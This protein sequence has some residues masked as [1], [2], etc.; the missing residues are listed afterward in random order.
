[1]SDKFRKIDLETWER[2]ENYTV[3]TEFMPCGV[4]MNANVDITD[5]INKIKGT[6]DKERIDIITKY[7]RNQLENAGAKHT[8]NFDIQRENG[9]FKMSLI[10]ATKNKN[11][12]D[13]MKEVLNLLSSK[14]TNQFVYLI[15]KHINQECLEL[16]PKDEIIITELASYIYDNYKSKHVKSKE[17]K[18]KVK[19]HP[20]IPSKY[21]TKAMNILYDTHKIYSV[22]KFD[23]AIA[24]K[25]SYPD[26]SIITFK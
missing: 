14:N 24:K 25:H 5:L 11:G 9:H 22:I 12:F 15:D 18:E 13:S 16:Y 1:M 3:F 19:E 10:Y 8:L 4:Q 20:Y 23:G 17:V 2:K 7:Y 6:A 21:F 26:D